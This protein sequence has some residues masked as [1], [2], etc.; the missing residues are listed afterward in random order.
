MTINSVQNAMV[1]VL[2][3][4]NAQTGIKTVLRADQLKAGNNPTLVVPRTSCPAIIVGWADTREKWWSNGIAERMLPITLD[5]WF[6]AGD[7]ASDAG[8]F[9][10]LVDNIA[11][12]MRRNAT[13][14]SLGDDTSLI[15][16]TTHMLYLT[17]QGQTQHPKPF[18]TD[19]KTAVY[20]D[21]IV[22][23]CR[24]EIRT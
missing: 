8:I 1:S 23:N 10:T 17:V 7:I 3:G 4:Y 16:G 5:V 6:Y 21:R 9:D 12:I 14:Q 19:G 2:S 11:A 18:A 15:V 22:V 13:L 20:H 24:E